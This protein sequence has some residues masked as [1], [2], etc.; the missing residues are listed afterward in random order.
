[1]K[2]FYE[3]NEKVLNSKINCPFED[4]LDMTPDHFT[5]WVSEVRK[6]VKDSWDTTD[7]PPRSGRSEEQ[8]IKG[9]NKLSTYNTQEMIHTDELSDQENDVIL[10]VA[11]KGTEVDQFFPTMMK[12]RINYSNKDNGYS[13]YDMFA[14]DKFQDRMVKGFNRHFKRDSFYHYSMGIKK[15]QYPNIQNGISWVLTFAKNP[16]MFKDHDFWLCEVKQQAGKN[17]GYYQVEQSDFFVL[18][19]NEVKQCWEAEYLTKRQVSNID[20]NDLK[21]DCIYMVRYF[22]KG[23]KVFPKAFTAFKIGYIQVAT[24]FPPMTAKYL[25]ERFTED[26]KDQEVIN[27]YDPSSGWGG[28]ILGAMSVKDDRKIH[29]I[30]TDP[31][32]DNYIADLGMTR[33]EYMAEFFNTQTYRGNP[34]FSETNTHDIF[35][36]GSEVIHMN[37]RFQKYKGQLDL[38][39][40]SPPY[41]AKEA[42][43]DDPNQSYKKFPTYEGWRDG[44]LKQ[45]L[46]TAVEYLKPGRYLLWNIADANFAG[47]F[48][49]LQTDS[50]K[51]LEDLGMVYQYDLKM[52]MALMPGQNRVDENG[53]PKCLNYCRV[54]SKYLKHEP[55][56]VFRK[57]YI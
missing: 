39:F 27:I 23:Q 57:P 29:Y 36:D 33:Y 51:I 4:L 28:R 12:T 2:Y 14:D 1:M 49:P 43:S 19:A 30:G 45:T 10:N 50:R 7:C 6:T 24:N 46:T 44:F 40:T 8:I 15:K 53:I 9:F 55:V 3:R 52:A 31:N 17:T 13:V 42:Y 16:Q 47:K 37:P 5:I 56:M 21:D 35:R 34:F 26:I 20:V 11:R 41:F 18:S 38:V 25:Y 54:D 32:P 48:M 22:K